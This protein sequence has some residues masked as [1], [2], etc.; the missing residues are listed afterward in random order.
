MAAVNLRDA[1]A[2]SPKATWEEKEG[3][4]TSPKEASSAMEEDEAEG[5][6]G[7]GM[8][9]SASSAAEEE[10][11]LDSATTEGSSVA[12][13]IAAAASGSGI[14]IENERVA[15]EL[16]PLP[17]NYSTG[18]TSTPKVSIEQLEE[19]F[20]PDVVTKVL[21][22][23][24]AMLEGVNVVLFGPCS[25]ALQYDDGDDITASACVGLVQVAAVCLSAPLWGSLA[26]RRI[27]QRKHILIVGA[28]GGGV[29]SIASAAVTMVTPLICLRAFSGV[30]LASQ[31]P[32]LNAVIADSTS[33][34]RRGSVY[35][36]VQAAL[37]LGML[38]TL[39]SAGAIDDK[40]VLGF[41]GW[42][43]LLGIGGCLS[44]FVG[45]LLKLMM[46]EPPREPE[47]DEVHSGCAIVLDEVK[48]T[49]SIFRTKSFCILVLQGIFGTIICTCL[50]SNQKLFFKLAGISDTVATV[51]TAEQLFVVA[52]G[53]VI[54]GHVG[55]FLAK[56]SG[57]HGRPLSAQIT[58]ALSMPFVY[59][60]YTGEDPGRGE[61]VTYA[62]LIAMWGVVGCWAQSGTNL[63]ILAE[64]VPPNERNRVM[65]WLYAL[66]NSVAKVLGPPVISFIAEHCYGYTFGEDKDQAGENLHSAK[67]LGRVM[68]AVIMGPT[69]VCLI[70]YSFLHFT[71]PADVNKI[72]ADRGIRD[73]HHNRKQARFS[74]ARTPER[75]RREKRVRFSE[76]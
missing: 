17:Q 51:L 22:C 15:L 56:K 4:A 11:E 33:E 68:T 43:L 27:L 21:L 26:D 62:I 75:G 45:C 74:E 31:R 57:L 76:V 1:A 36:K 67:A 9:T 48:C 52:V 71:Y 70:A 5:Y 20:E 3:L 42:R 46:T 24:I 73:L 34:S 13:S 40:T 35:G 2:K 37:F 66:E 16:P 18:A 39:L 54:G 30:M 7:L 38:L 72:L 25:L 69:F 47:N 61:V 60:L 63:P 23:I 65:A 6:A 44:L 59:F 14:G 58:L 50:I 41:Q 53:S 12:V 10:I 32:I 19:D 28:I 55:D 8:G 64:I 49:I 29:S